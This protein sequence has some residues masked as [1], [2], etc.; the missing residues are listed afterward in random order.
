VTLPKAR[1]FQVATKEVAVE[2]P[3]RDRL[4]EFVDEAMKRLRDVLRA[5]VSDL[6]R[7]TR[8]LAVLVLRPGSAEPA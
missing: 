3:R 7:G 8:S 6:R 5:R 4:V 1:R 2:L